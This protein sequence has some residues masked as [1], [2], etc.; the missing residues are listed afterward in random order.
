MKVETLFC[1]L[2]LLHSVHQQHIQKP[3]S[4]NMSAGN[5][6]EASLANFRSVETHI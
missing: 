1:L 3:A 4:L 6:E 5:F 2:L